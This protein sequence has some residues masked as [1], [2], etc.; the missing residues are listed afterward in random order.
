MRPFLWSSFLLPSPA[1]GILGG[2]PSRAEP[3]RPCP[4]AARAAAQCRAGLLSFDHS[5]PVNCRHLLPFPSLPAGGADSEAVRAEL[6][7]LDRAVRGTVLGH[8]LARGLFLAHDAAGTLRRAQER[9]LT[10]QKP[11]GGGRGRGA[12]PGRWFIVA[13][14]HCRNNWRAAVLGQRWKNEGGKTR[15]GGEGRLGGNSWGSGPGVSPWGPSPALPRCLD[16]F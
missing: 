12:A 5:L 2:T 16:I 10:G 6:L 8:T 7:S 1:A 9:A 11:R 3:R 15:H 14:G 13:G 4:Q